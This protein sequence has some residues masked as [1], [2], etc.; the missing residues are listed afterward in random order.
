MQLK[1]KE[2]ILIFL[3]TVCVGGYWLHYAVERG[4]WLDELDWTLAFLH[5]KSLLSTI[6]ELLYYGYN[7]PLFYI[8]LKPVYLISHNPYILYIP[9]VLC[10]VLGA[11]T[12]YFIGKK[13]YGRLCGGIVLVLTLLSPM[14]CQS[15]AAQIRPYG[16]LF[17]LSALTLY[18]Y[19]KRLETENKKTILIYGIVITC[20]VYT[21]WFASLMVATYALTDL[22]LWIKKKIKF[23][24]VISYLICGFAF[25]PWL[26]AL[27]MLHK[28]NFQDYWGNQIPGLSDMIDLFSSLL[29]YNTFLLFV[30]IF[31]FIRIFLSFILGVKDD[32]K[33]IIDW[34]KQ[35]LYACLFVLFTIWI[36]TLIMPKAS[37][38]VFRYF[39][40]FLP[41]V[42]LLTSYGIWYLIRHKLNFVRFFYLNK[43]SF[44]FKVFFLSIIIYGTVAAVIV[45]E[46]YTKDALR[47]NYFYKFH[48]L[49][50]FFS[51]KKLT[52]K[53]LLL[54][55]GSS[56]YYTFFKMKENVDL[57]INYG[58]LYEDKNK[59]YT[60]V[61]Y[62]K[63]GSSFLTPYE[64]VPHAS[65]LNYDL[66]YIIPDNFLDDILELFL[67][68]NFMCKH[69]PTKTDNVL[70]IQECTRISDQ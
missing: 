22:Y 55:H 11:I 63:K 54:S 31:V 62:V 30:F 17:F 65:L 4:M 59:Q 2:F 64:K 68:K 13:L 35:F 46:P 7:L 5:D 3:I 20:Y 26:I 8:L 49:S 27:L 41:Q 15:V 48:E 70:T 40:V 36:Y 66:I 10:T 16:L 9:S 43:F 38:F 21:H 51:D 32:N 23:R 1:V 69:Y 67:S 18:S 58:M 19:L 14:V 42:L 39:K 45:S 47:I 44:L 6:K 28:N 50:D 52:K 60:S 33:H 61:Y 29:G 12:L 34:P 37:L 57:A 53:T 56:F 24:C 25:L